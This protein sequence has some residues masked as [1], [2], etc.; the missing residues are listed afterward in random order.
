[1]FDLATYLSQKRKRIDGTLELI[2]QAP[3]GSE[4]I[5]DAMR[6]S[7]MA[8]G[9]RL[10]PILCLASI[11]AVAG[12]CS[13]E[14]ALKT[15]GALEM[16]HTYSLIHDDLP[17]MDDDDLRR[18]IPTCHIAFDEPTAIL[19][20][21]ALLTLAFQTLAEI[22][23][24]AEREALKLIGVIRSIARAAGHL[25]MIAGQMIDVSS[26]GTRLSL[27]DLQ[28]MYRMKTGALI[29][30]S[31]HCG[32]VIG[33]ASEQQ[34]DCLATYAENLGLAFQI[35]DDILNIQGDPAVMGKSAG[36]D[37]IRHKTTYPVVMGIEKSRHTMRRLVDNA[38]Q[39]LEDF[40]NKS[41]PLR[42]IAK[43]IIERNL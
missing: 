1:M 20:G 41:D 28:Q 4:R 5:N 22:D 30:T 17:A 43:Y 23:C 35:A 3:T 7:V 31:V 9:K 19:A 18:G 34:T 40:D 36:T 8:G 12:D 21:D 29:E 16:I 42:A 15:A 11:E 27:A 10:R 38:L 6:Y 13:S 25:G 24:E 32:T 2:F 26:E 14:I 37:E 39:A 33:G